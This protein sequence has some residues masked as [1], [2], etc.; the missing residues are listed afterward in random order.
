MLLQHCRVT[1]GQFFRGFIILVFVSAML[2]GCA[3]L[4]DT[5][6]YTTATIQVKQLVETVGN[7]VEIELD[8]AG[9]VSGQKVKDFQKAWKTTVSSLDAM[10]TYAE[11]IEQIVD[12]GNKGANSA[13]QVADS[14]KK[15]ADSVKV[16]ALTGAA[17]EVFGVAANTGAFVYGEIAKIGAANNLDDALSKAD[18]WVV[19]ISNMVQLQVEDAGRLFHRQ[20]K[21]QVDDLKT[22][23]EA[24]YGDWI[25]LNKKIDNTQLNSLKEMEKFLNASP[26]DLEKVKKLQTELDEVEKTRHQIAPHILEYKTK[27]AE[28]RNR[29]TAGL[30]LIRASENAIAAWGAAHQNLVWAVK[31]R[32]P[33]SVESITMAVVQIRTLI[34]KWRIL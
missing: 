24:G 18:P 27:L 31:E 22:G 28:I 29:E 23:G 13:R 20:I 6:N 11:S 34:E 9:T 19:R 2:G 26:M 17:G 21:D 3:T 12:A 7:V 10:I 8:S 33:V 16:D 4:P 14:V 1:K 25:K 32:K 30:N 5:S 15:L